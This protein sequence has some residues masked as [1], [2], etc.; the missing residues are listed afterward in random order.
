M[1]RE[2]ALRMAI[3]RALRHLGYLVLTQ[4]GSAYTGA[5]R[6][7]LIGCADGRFFAIEVKLPSSRNRVTEAQKLFLESVR[8][9]GGIAFVA[10]SVDEAIEALAHELR[11]AGGAR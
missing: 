3:A 1:K 8:R 4:H 5:G 9:A 6:A 7:D 11:W 2:S 10:S